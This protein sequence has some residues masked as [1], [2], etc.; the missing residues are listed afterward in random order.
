VVL[1]VPTGAGKTLPIIVASLETGKIGIII[2]PL[3][4]LEQQIERDLKS[5]NIGYIN[6]T[7]TK[8]EDLDNLLKDKPDIILTNVE[9]LGDK[10]KRD[11]LC[12][13]RVEIGHVAWDEAVVRKRRSGGEEGLIGHCVLS[14]G[15]NL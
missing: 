12:K 1:A 2:L 6:M 8:A 14:S 13:S 5:L 9:A 4:S 10:T 3:L 11:V 15:D 7:T